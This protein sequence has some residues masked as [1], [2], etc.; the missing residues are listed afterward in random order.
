MFQ[1]LKKPKIIIVVRDICNFQFN[2]QKPSILTKWE[3]L[4]GSCSSLCKTST[5]Y[6]SSKF[7]FYLDTE[8]DT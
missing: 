3:I 8:K 1:W 7:S 6:E 4:F 2:T 5:Q